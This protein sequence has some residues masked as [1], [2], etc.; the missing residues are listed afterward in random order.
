M[1]VTVER[2]VEMPE[3]ALAEIASE[4]DRT[5]CFFVRRLK[6]EWTSGVN[7]FSEPGEALFGAWLEGRLVG[8]GGLNV[9]P[10][11]GDERVGRVRRLYVLQGFRRRGVATLLVQAAL[12]A[13]RGRFRE[14]R[15]RTQN[16]KAGQFYE[17]LG[18]LPAVD[19]ADCT[20]VMELRD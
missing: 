4:A 18:F 16:D 17:R 2:L 3:L 1:A 7:R 11:A 19:R 15:L 9:D 13:A 12:N 8:V 6:E 5:G 14:L 10:Y 20:H